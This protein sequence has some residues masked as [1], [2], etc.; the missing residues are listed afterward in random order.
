MRALFLFVC[1]ARGACL[2]APLPVGLFVCAVARGLVCLRRCPWACL[3]APVVGSPIRSLIR[4][5]APLWFIGATAP[6]RLA[7]V[8]RRGW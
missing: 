2:F 4:P 7:L 6:L 5:T 1:V 3:F 8:V